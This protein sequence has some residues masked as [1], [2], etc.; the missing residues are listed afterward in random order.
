MSVVMTDVTSGRVVGFTMHV[1]VS[2]S[3]NQSR[4]CVD[5]NK[6]QY[7]FSFILLEAC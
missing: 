7:F 5:T 4:V 6:L 3:G 2:M 1:V